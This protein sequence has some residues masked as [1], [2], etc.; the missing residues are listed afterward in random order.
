MNRVKELR[1]SIKLTQKALAEHIGVHQTAV[2]QWETGRTTPDPESAAKIAKLCRVSLDY[3]L[4]LDK[5]ESTVDYSENIGKGIRVPVYGYVAAG[6][7]IE[8]ISSFD[9]DDPNDWE[10]I[11]SHTARQGDFFALRI[12]G[13][14]MEPKISEGDIVV[15]RRQPDVQTGDIAIVCISGEE[16]TCKK[17]KKTDEGII[18]ISL[19]PSYE[20]MF[21]SNKQISSL[22]LTILGRVVELRAKF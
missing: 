9:S 22:P 7:P 11:D 5:M 16:A 15:V 2:S 12:K 21:Y 19:N 13:D 14:S 8:A 6:I 18:L 17:V 4:G 10:E 1:C 3:V 20:P